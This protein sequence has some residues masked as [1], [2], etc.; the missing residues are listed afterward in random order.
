MQ[1]GEAQHSHRFK[2]SLRLFSYEGG[3]VPLKAINIYSLGWHRKHLL[4]SVLLDRTP[5]TDRI[6]LSFVYRN[7][8]GFVMLASSPIRPGALNPERCNLCQA[9]L[10]SVKQPS[11]PLNL[12][13]SRRNSTFTCPSWWR[14]KFE[15]GAQQDAKC[16]PGSQTHTRSSP[17]PCSGPLRKRL[18]SETISD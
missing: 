4:V 16:E 8:F 3:S 14:W 5:C 15:S 9:I 6:S 11:L 12:L 1:F 13:C 17:G 10:I 18:R 7:V 2:H